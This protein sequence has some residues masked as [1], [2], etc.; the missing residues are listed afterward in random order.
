MKK[1]LKI[2]LC[3][4]ICLTGGI[5]LAGCL[6]SNKNN[7]V[8]DNGTTSNQESETK[9]CYISVSAN[10]ASRGNVYGDG[11]YEEGT[12]VTIKAV[13]S[14]GYYF[15]QWDDGSKQAERQ[16][17]ARYQIEYYTAYFAKDDGILVKSIYGA[18]VDLVAK[19]GIITEE[20]NSYTIV[21]KEKE[22]F[23]YW[24]NTNNPSDIYD[25]L[26]KI[27][28]KKSNIVN[29]LTLTAYNTKV[30]YL[31]ISKSSSLSLPSG[32]LGFS[33][34]VSSDITDYGYMRLDTGYHT[35]NITV[36]I[37]NQGATRYKSKIHCLATLDQADNY[38]VYTIFSVRGVLKC[39]MRDGWYGQW[40]VSS[41]GTTTF[42][43]DY[44]HVSFAFANN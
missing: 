25:T 19:Y 33:E 12:A 27:T 35:S 1:L 28:I 2:I 13:A 3:F 26:S 34:V 8:Q 44:E 23:S 16:V 39:K 41:H 17:E 4:T 24:S 22:T 30:G 31:F 11:T 40:I 37:E 10:D 38:G 5:M 20:S 18:Y 36:T 21:P 9:T 15:Y 6:F 14:P 42:D 7:E 43:N 32:V 29:G